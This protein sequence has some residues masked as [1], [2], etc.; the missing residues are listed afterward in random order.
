VLVAAAGRL[1]RRVDCDADGSGKRLVKRYAGGAD[2][3]PRSADSLV[4]AD[5]GPT[6]GQDPSATRGTIWRLILATGQVSQRTHH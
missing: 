3:N 2:W 1:G 5:H 4:V 6:P